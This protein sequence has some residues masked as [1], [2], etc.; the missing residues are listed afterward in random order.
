M[1]QR[2]NIIVKHLIRRAGIFFLLCLIVI[3]GFF[4]PSLLKAEKEEKVV[5]VG[6]YESAFHR[7]DQFGRKSGYGYEYQQVVATFTGWRY[8]YVEGSWSE[9]FEMLVDGKIDLL[10]DVSYTA[11]RAEK[12]L[13]SAEEM[14][15]EDYHAFIA[16][17]N[18]E[19]RPDDF[20]TFNDKRVGVNKNSFQEQLLKQWAE[21][22]DVHPQIIELTAK[23]PQLLEMLAKGDIDV[24]VTLDTYGNSADVVPVCKIGSSKIYFGINKNRPDLKKDL[25]MA[26]NRML[27]ANRDFNQQ[28]TEKFNKAYAVNSFLSAEETDWLDKH[29][30]IRIGYRDDFL[31]FCDQSETG[32][33]TGALKYFFD[34]A[35]DCEKN[36]KL[37]FETIAYKTTEAALQA[38]QNKEIDCIFPVN[39]SAYDGEQ[40]GVIITDPFVSTE[41]YAAMRT[42]DHE[43]VSPDREMNV[44]VLN[45]HPN[46]ETFLKDYFPNWKLEYRNSNEENFKALSDGEADCTLVSSYRLDRVREL[47]DR[48]DLSVLATG[49]TMDLCFATNKEDDCL[50]SILNKVMNLYP[51]TAVNSALTSYAYRDK[52]V[53]VGEFIRDNLVL[54]MIF[55]AAIASIITILALRGKKAEDSASEGRA[56]ISETERDSLTGLYNWNFF[57]AYANRIHREH[58]DWHVDAAVINIE[59]FH[60]INDL[61]G[62]DFGDT[63]LKKLGEQINEFLTNAK[64]IACRF[65]ADRFDIYC[66][67]REDWPKVLDDFQEKINELSDNASVRL[68]MGVK[69]WEEGME[70]I[71]QFDR[72]RTACNT[73]RGDFKR[74]LK[75]YDKKMGRK[76]EHDQRLLNDLRKALEEKQF[77]VWYQPKYNIKN[78]PPVL[79]SAEALARWNHPELGIISPTEFIRL[80]ESDGQISLLDHY[81]WEEAAKNVA[82]WRREYG[83]RIAVSVNLSRVD[84]F[85]PNLIT[86]L[87]D[88]IHKYELDYKDLKL[89][90]TESAYT[91]NADYLIMVIEK[92]REIGYE[93]EM[94]DFGSGYSSLNMLSAMPVDILK[95]DMA[96]VRNIE[97]NVNDQH[98][99][100]LIIDIARY[101]KV[102]VIAEGVE[103]EKQ[104]KL[105]KDVGCDIVQGFYF[106]KP[107]PAREFEQKIIIKEIKGKE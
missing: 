63:I 72:A 53:T 52:R 88:I 79:A 4:F 49:E 104:L 39:L 54:F 96:F 70:P 47:C 91:E 102:P 65:D 62:R 76:E 17:D 41:M 77:E 95:M 93:I 101:L 61:H 44:T 59:R 18:T 82:R 45:G 106:S 51:D 25:D 28:M 32:E 81:V 60:S 43:G 74:Q 23:T 37:T 56:L 107:L 78:D 11:E 98:L 21:N 1:I 85:D 19:I 7:T 87:N 13:Y 2:K 12:I 20:S 3:S 67:S 35:E 55:V 80:L 90:V 64:G 99:V 48:Y 31:P 30:T 38:L 71:A 6:W 26:M 10:S 103:T 5:R 97:R 36:A 50:Y 84:V 14:G 34:F 66:L 24:L 94:D 42:A 75:I 73:N 92:L 83:I 57:L 89:E 40:L 15:S 86:T 105:L 22:H 29:G 9:L 68:R 69:P 8:E 46:H 100:E 58:P 27:E 16:P 33:L